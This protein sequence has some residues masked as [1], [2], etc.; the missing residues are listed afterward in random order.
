MAACCMSVCP[1]S[2]QWL[3]PYL[4]HMPPH[5]LH[6]RGAAPQVHA[7][8]VGR[9]VSSD[10]AAGEV[11]LWRQRPIAKP[12]RFG[13]GCSCLLRTST[14]GRAFGNATRA[15]A[16]KQLGTTALPKA[17]VP[18]GQRLPIS[19]EPGVPRIGN[20]AGISYRISVMALRVRWSHYLSPSVCK[21]EVSW[22]THAPGWG[23]ES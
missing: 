5:L 16:A 18:C 15:A 2:S 9:H 22:A 12:V 10:V 21:R 20:G 14:T 23:T 1:P 17:L 11:N 6:A 13:A 8:S 3:C 7:S 4:P 19:T